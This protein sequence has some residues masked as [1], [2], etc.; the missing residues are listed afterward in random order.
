MQLHPIIRQSALLL[1]F[2]IGLQAPA[3]NSACLEGQERSEGGQERREARP[4]QRENKQERREARPERQEVKQERREDRPDRRQDNR[5]QR[6]QRDLRSQQEPRELREPR[7]VP[8]MSA[9]PEPMP[10]PLPYG[11]SRENPQ[12]RPN[13]RSMEHSAPGS[14]ALTPDHRY[15]PPSRS[16]IQAQT[17]ERSH[18]WQGGGAW[19]AH[20]TWQQHRA[21]SWESEHRSWEHRGGYGGYIIPQSRFRLHFGPDRWFRIRTR[22]MIYMGYPRFRYGSYWFRIVD[23]WPEFWSDSW[24]ANDDVYIDYNDGYYLYNRRH[25]GVAIAVSVSL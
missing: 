13:P 1:A 9:R 16:R 10:R 15:A 12:P 25:P 8:P 2:G 6:E 14:T 5:G 24:Y 11:R 21:G 4:E 3:L 22:P 23:P 19:A 18:G 20:P 17:W 7:H